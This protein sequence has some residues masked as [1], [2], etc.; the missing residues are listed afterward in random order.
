MRIVSGFQESR[1]FKRALSSRWR[2]GHANM[3]ATVWIPG[4]KMLYY[5]VQLLI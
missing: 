4:L 5:G 2:R 3:A 1:P